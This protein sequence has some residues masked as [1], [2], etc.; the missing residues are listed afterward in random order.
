MRE[1]ERRW[2]VSSTIG[3]SERASSTERGSSTRA[4]NFSRH[5]II[6]SFLPPPSLSLFIIIFIIPRI[7]FLIPPSHPRSL[8]VSFI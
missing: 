6:L 7:F 3:E 4:R 5:A 2:A 1:G 8:I